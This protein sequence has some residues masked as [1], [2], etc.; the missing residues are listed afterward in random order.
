MKPCIPE[1]RHVKTQTNIYDEDPCSS[2]VP[3][4]VIQV[5]SNSGSLIT[6]YIPD[7]ILQLFLELNGDLSMKNNVY[8]SRYINLTAKKRLNK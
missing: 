1:T 3:D 6:I 2:R 4:R 5:K 7:E 8:D